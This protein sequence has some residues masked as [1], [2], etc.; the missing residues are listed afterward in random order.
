MIQAIKRK[1]EY[2][3][4]A[5]KEMDEKQNRSEGLIDA[6]RKRI[7]RLQS[8]LDALR[9]GGSPVDTPDIEPA[10][11]ETAATAGSGVDQSALDSLQKMIQ[12][13]EGNLIRRI[14][15]LEGDIH[16]IGTLEDEMALMRVNINQLMMPKEPVIDSSDVDRWNL[17][18][19][20][21]AELEDYIMKL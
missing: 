3:E 10:P 21:T 2:N 5:L 8:D 13:V 16:R 9:K 17:N 7:A 12:R 6:N 18:V 11:I 20:K 19:K 15:A 14:A 4:N 1:V